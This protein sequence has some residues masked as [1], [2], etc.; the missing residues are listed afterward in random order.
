MAYAD[1][2]VESLQRKFHRMIY[3]GRP[4]DVAIAAITRELACFIWGI[5][6]KQMN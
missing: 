2:A 5:E 6:T 1:R 4:R 3:Q